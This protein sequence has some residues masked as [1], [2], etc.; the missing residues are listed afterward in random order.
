MYLDVLLSFIRLGVI[1][2]H[3]GSG[4]TRK[5][6]K[7]SP[8][9]RFDFSKTLDWPDWKQN[10]LRF[11]LA[12]NLHKEDGDVQVSALI[13]RMGKEAEHMYKSFTLEKGDE[14]KFDVILAKIDGHFLLKRN[15]IHERARFHQ[16]NQKQG[17]SIESIVRS[18]CELREQFVIADT[19][20][21]CHQNF[22]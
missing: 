12:T 2:R 18:L 13:Y 1:S 11:R 9:D 4:E 5:M 10:F 22:R 15:T 16:R 21:D 8:P 17:E 19:R 14:A 20:Q 6:L 7:L 3:G